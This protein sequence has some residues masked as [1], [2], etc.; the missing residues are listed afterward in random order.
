MCVC[1]FALLVLA[2]QIHVP[3]EIRGQTNVN[4]GVRSREKFTAGLNKEDGWFILKNPNSLRVLGGRAFKG[5]T[6]GRVAGCV[7]SF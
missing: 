4:I 3:K 6:G 5:K 1:A 7:A 2:I